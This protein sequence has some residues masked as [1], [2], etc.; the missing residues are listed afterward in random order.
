LKG[1]YLVGGVEHTTEMIPLGVLVGSVEHTI[2][3]TP[4]TSPFPLEGNNL[5]GSVE[6]TTEILSSPS[7]IDVL[8][9]PSTEMALVRCVEHTT[10]II[11]GDVV[12]STSPLPLQDNPSSLSC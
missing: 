1:E 6:H 12:A 5:V 10:E 4:G 11:L 2:E 8:N 9:D 3:L 7:L